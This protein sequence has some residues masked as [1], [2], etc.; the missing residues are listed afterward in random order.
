MQVQD[1]NIE[2]PY[3][4][5]EGQGEVPAESEQGN[6]ESY[7]KNFNPKRLGLN[8]RTGPDRL[9]EKDKRDFVAELGHRGG[10]VFRKVIALH[11]IG[12]RPAREAP[13]MR[14][15]V[16]NPHACLTM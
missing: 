1:I 16:G 9:V 15:Q 8:N 10:N 12:E 14:K 7:G 2:P 5:N 3:L 4:P 6:R 11:Y 13:P